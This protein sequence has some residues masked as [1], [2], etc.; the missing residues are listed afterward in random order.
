[1]PLDVARGAVIAVQARVIE[2]L[3]AENGRLAGQVADLAVRVER[4][5]TSRWRSRWHLRG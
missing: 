4:R 5:R 2:V 3:A 1:M